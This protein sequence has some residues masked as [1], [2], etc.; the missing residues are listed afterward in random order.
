MNVWQYE[1]RVAVKIMNIMSTN[2]MPLEAPP[3][4][5]PGLAKIYCSTVITIKTKHYIEAKERAAH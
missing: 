3:A 4:I 1:M 2:P 5:S